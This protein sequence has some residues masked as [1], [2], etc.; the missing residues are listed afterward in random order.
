MNPVEVRN[1][2][3]GE[4]IP[5]ICVPI[6]GVTKEDIIIEAKTFDSIPADV[7]EWR[8]DWFEHV[9]ELEKVK[10]VLAEL[11]AA[12]KDIPLLF[13]FRT[14]KEGG[15]KSIEP[16]AYAALNK[17]AAQTGHIDLVDVEVFTG[18]DIVKDIVEAAHAAGVKVVASNH[19]FDKTPDKDDI[20]GRLCK[21]QELGAD[22]PKIAV[23]PQNKKDVLTLL[24]ATE[25]MYREHADRPIITMSM[26]G[27]GV[28]S[29]L[30]G[31]VF[32]SALTFGAAKKASAPGQMS[33]G[34]LAQVLSLL[35]KS[36]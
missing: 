7:V 14:S 27:T 5:K 33:V 36:L 12:L 35:H 21:M 23:M 15:E 11:R 18:D 4:G 20:V 2:K 17:A 6:V 26:A 16:E 30:C 34:D 22:I 8:V 19:D 32:G 25:E 28:I 24:A 3:I 31:E 1:I 29:R 9:F 10:E 13:T